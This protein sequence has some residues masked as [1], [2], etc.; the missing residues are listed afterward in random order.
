MLKAVNNQAKYFCPERSS[1]HLKW[2]NIHLEYEIYIK[3]KILINIYPFLNSRYPIPNHY[4]QITPPQSIVTWPN[5]NR[6][7][8]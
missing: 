7:I 8:F 6:C 4:M 5:E 3:K 1:S 2:I